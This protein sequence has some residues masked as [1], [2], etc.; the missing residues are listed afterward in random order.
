MLTKYELTRAETMI[1][2]LAGLPD[3][4][5][6]IALDTIAAYSR[7][8]AWVEGGALNAVIRSRHL[9]PEVRE[10]VKGCRDDVRRALEG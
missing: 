8:L 2:A 7:V 10:A 9:S 6:V 5:A 3:D 1:Q 4:V